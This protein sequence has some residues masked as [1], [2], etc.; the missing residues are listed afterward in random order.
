MGEALRHTYYAGW[1]DCGPRAKQA[2]GYEEDN[3]RTTSNRREA[4]R[5]FKRT[6]T[7]KTDHG[8]VNVGA[9]DVS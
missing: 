1:S 9:I 8:K 4:G 6:Q 5:N 2:S 7:F 3:N